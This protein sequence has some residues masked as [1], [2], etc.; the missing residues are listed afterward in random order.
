MVAINF[1]VFID[2]IESGAKRQTIR[3]T[4][5]CKVG[6][7]L[8]LYTGMRHKNCRKLGD[9]VCEAVLPI[10]I[11]G[12]AYHIGSSHLP[13]HEPEQLDSM[14]KL[15]GFASWSAME[16]FF[17]KNYGLPFEGVLIRWKDFEPTPRLNP[18]G[19]QVCT[20]E[21]GE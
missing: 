14:A 17:L 12:L 8:Q 2:K 19:T 21:E 5:R 9:A 10:S 18:D 11:W 20:R 4:A 13:V 7:K 1:T 3:Q 15:D 16:A 6:D